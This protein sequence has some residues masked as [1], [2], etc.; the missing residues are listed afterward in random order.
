MSTTSR[1]LGKL[2]KKTDP[3][4]LRLARYAVS[5][6]APPAA[7]DWERPTDWGMLGNDTVGDCTCAAAGHAIQ[8]W[9]ADTASEAAVTTAQV[10]AAYSAV[11][12]YTPTDPSTDQGAVCLDVLNYWRKTGI[13]GHRIGAFAELNVGD[14]DEIRAAVDLFGL[15]YVGAALPAT[16][17][18]ELDDGAPWA[19]TAGTPGGWGGHCFIVGAY[20]VDGLT[21]ITWGQRQRMTWEWFAKYVDEAYAVLSPDWLGPKGAPNGFDLAALQTDL[22]AVTGAGPLVGP[23]P[24]APEPGAAPFP[25]ATA[26]VAT[27]V[28]HAAARARLSTSGWLN[29]HLEAYFDL[30][31]S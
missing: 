20:D 15:I 4:T 23:T 11:T 9:T 13:A 22:S 16:A 26:D 30:K 24:P 2:P 6:W 12:G 21:C 29:R 18:A 17:E 25:G 27:H 10:L 8:E 31:E 14:E 1:A 19:S 3:R 7:A 28:A 5:G